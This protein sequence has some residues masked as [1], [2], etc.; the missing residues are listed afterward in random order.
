MV[1]S[2]IF[3][4]CLYFSVFFCVGQSTEGTFF[5]V[6]LPRTAGTFD[7]LVTMTAREET[8]YTIESSTETRQ[9]TIPAMGSVTEVY[10][11]EQ[12]VTHGLETVGL[13]VTTDNPIS[14]NL[15]QPSW[16][17]DAG[18]ARP[19]HADGTEFFVVSYLNEKTTPSLRPLSFYSVVASEDDTTVEILNNERRAKVVVTLDKFEV[20]SEDASEYEDGSEFDYTGVY[21]RSD[22]PVSVYAGHG[23]VQ[24]PD[25]TNNNYIYDSMP[26]TADLGTAHTTFPIIY[27]PDDSGYVL[28]VLA[29]TDGTTV[30]I[31]SLDVSEEIN[32]GEFYELDHRVARDAIKVITSKSPRFINAL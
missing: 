14:V 18:M 30:S 5:A 15:D 27:G 17:V 24:F 9:G 19:I 21:V 6:S 22:K 23:R 1:Y 25:N 4:P 28:R 16:E 13:I 12:R 11:M 2:K 20:I 32:T 8:S 10:P 26:N 31:S 7:C 29:V 3:Q